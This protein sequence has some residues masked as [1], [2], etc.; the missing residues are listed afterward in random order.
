MNFQQPAPFV[1]IQGVPAPMMPNF[2]P[3][4]AAPDSRPNMTIPEQIIASQ[5]PEVNVQGKGACL[6]AICGVFLKWFL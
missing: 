4:G 3:H 6:F 1:P 5:I 2:Y